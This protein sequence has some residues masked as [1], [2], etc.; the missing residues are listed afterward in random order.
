MRS[1]AN[2]SVVSESQ[3]VTCRS[4]ILRDEKALPQ[5]SINVDRAR[6][7][8]RQAFAR[9]CNPLWSRNFSKTPGATR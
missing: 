6:A 2:S 4:V 7:F 8:T 5:I 9:E 1:A 3:S